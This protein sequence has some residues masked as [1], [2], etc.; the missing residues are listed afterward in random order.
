[1][2]ANG[3]FLLHIGYQAHCGLK[4]GYGGGGVW[5]S[6]FLD[7]GVEIFIEDGHFLAISVFI[8]VTG[9]KPQKINLG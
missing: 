8:I 6:A 5:F 4:Q 3:L 2:H 1:M 9:I 7:F